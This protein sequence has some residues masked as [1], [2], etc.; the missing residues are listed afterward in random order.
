MTAVHRRH[1]AVAVVAFLAVGCGGADDAT[2]LASD[3][4]PSVMATAS[5]LGSE[6]M[7][8]MDTEA[9]QET[10]STLVESASDAMSEM[11]TESAMDASSDAMGDLSGMDLPEGFPTD[12]PVPEGF[13][14]TVT[15]SQLDDTLSAFTL[16]GRIDSDEDPAVV[17][18]KLVAAWEARGWEV[19]D[20]S[21]RPDEADLADIDFERDG[22]T[23]TVS[24][25]QDND[26]LAMSVEMDVMTGMDG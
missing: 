6:A 18:D 16:A 15:D 24:V 11:D 8:E 7:S 2:D 1:A 22:D 3:V 21:L 25:T 5:D 23:A 20:Q 9:V 13:V 26:G 17:V 14:P 10:A 12:I 4:D 19:V